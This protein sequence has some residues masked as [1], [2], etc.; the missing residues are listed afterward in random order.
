[1]LTREDATVGSLC[2][3]CWTPL[4]KVMVALF[5]PGTNRTKTV[6]GLCKQ[7]QFK[8]KLLERLDYLKRIEKEFARHSER[9]LV[10]SD[11]SWPALGT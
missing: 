9:M 1:M 4:T 11:L 7:C 3:H 10:A 8:A 2:M 5:S 6:R